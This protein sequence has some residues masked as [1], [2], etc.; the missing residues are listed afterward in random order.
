M[1]CD[2]VSFKHKSHS[3]SEAL[4]NPKVVTTDECDACN[5]RFSTSIE[6]ALIN[7][8]SV[9]RSL[10]G[11]S[12]KNGAKTVIGEN[13]VL[14]PVKGFSIQSDKTHQE[15]V[16]NSAQSMDLRLRDKF[17]PQDVYRCLVKFVLGVVDKDLLGEFSKTLAWINGEIDA[18]VLPCIAR[19]QGA[20]FF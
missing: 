8:V 10:Y 7:L 9:F 16:Q 6:P 2:K 17:V 14:D 13:F 3:I 12:G 4:G 18:E 5:D 20:I 1:L 15:I 11:L 19:H